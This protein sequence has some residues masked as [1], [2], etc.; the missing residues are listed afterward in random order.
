MVARTRRMEAAVHSLTFLLTV[1]EG[2][3]PKSWSPW[4]EDS[5]EDTAVA[6]SVDPESTTK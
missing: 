1:G 3:A 6:N 5:H 4:D 2:E